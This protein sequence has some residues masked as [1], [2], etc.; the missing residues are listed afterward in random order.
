MTTRTTSSGYSVED[1]A[2]LL[3]VAPRTVRRWLQEGRLGGQKIGTVWVVVLPEAH[4]P[5]STSGQ[6]TRL[7]VAPPLSAQLR[8]RLRQ[9]GSHL[10]TVGNATAGVR[11]AR[12]TVFLA[13]RRPGSV[14]LGFAIGR[15]SP[16]HGWAPHAL[17]TALPFWLKERAR[18]RR[19]LPLL[20]RYERLRLWCHPRLLRLPDVVALVDAD[21]T[22][23]E[24]ALT[25]LA[26]EVQGSPSRLPHNAPR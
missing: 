14:Q 22:R 10:L 8:T 11:P 13:W 9:I 26:H 5:P 4:T 6:A 3:G 12:G 15:V 25:V 17:G 16:T 23:L 2:S 24:A 19:V 21:L 18:W 1:T 7:P 20:G